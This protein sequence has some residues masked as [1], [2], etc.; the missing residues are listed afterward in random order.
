VD[1]RG[2]G[3]HAWNQVFAAYQRT[4]GE[5]LSLYLDDGTPL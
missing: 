5:P 4:F 3:F 2:P 1:A